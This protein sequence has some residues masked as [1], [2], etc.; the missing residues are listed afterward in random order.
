MQNPRQNM[1]KSN[2]I[3]WHFLVPATVLWSAGAEVSPTYWQRMVPALLIHA[4][5]TYLEPKGK[6]RDGR[7]GNSKLNQVYKKHI[8]K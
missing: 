8:S 4:H 6:C 1:S 7:T 3:G 2:P 5:L